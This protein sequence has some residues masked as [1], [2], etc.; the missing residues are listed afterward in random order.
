MCVASGSS[1]EP[2]ASN[3]SASAELITSTPSGSS[4]NWNCSISP[5]GLQSG[6]LAPSASNSDSLSVANTGRSFFH[7]AVVQSASLLSFRRSSQDPVAR[8]RSNSSRNVSSCTTSSSRSSACR[9]RAFR[10][11]TLMQSASDGSLSRSAFHSSSVP[12]TSGAN[13]MCLPKTGG[14]AHTLLGGRHPSF[15]AMR[16]L[17]SPNALRRSRLVKSDRDPELRS[18]SA[19]AL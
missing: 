14:P 11:S 4:N 3:T 16:P 7:P 13:G 10:R 9:P 1:I 17:P 18:D 6:K 2:S 15:V 19:N 5:P 12:G 8:Y